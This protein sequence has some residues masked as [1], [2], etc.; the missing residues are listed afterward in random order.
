[1]KHHTCSNNAMRYYTD[2]LFPVDVHIQ[3]PCQ[4]VPGSYGVPCERTCTIFCH[5][6]DGVSRNAT[7]PRSQHKQ[8]PTSAIHRFDAVS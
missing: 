7:C 3:R 8:I 6:S 2:R 1:M 5:A 4:K